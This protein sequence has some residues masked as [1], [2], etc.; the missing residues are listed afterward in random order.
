MRLVQAI[1]ISASILFATFVFAQPLI[2]SS[3]PDTHCADEAS[4]DQEH[5]KG[6]SHQSC[7]CS[8]HIAFSASLDFSPL[9]V[10]SDSSVKSSGPLA[11]DSCGDDFARRLYQPP[12]LS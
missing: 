7:D 6:S 9:E 4:H 12:R 8:C 11:E 10:F 1:M 2:P 5:E 3:C